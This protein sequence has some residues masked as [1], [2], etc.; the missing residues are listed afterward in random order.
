MGGEKP[1]YTESL[2]GVLRKSGVR[3]RSSPLQVVCYRAGMRLEGK[4][5]VNHL[6]DSQ[7]VW[8]P[9]VL[10]FCLDDLSIGEKGVWMTPVVVLESICCVVNSG[11]YFMK[12]C[13]LEYDMSV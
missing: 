12:L 8:P 9:S 5:S 7:P 10:S 3:W 2:G 13:V 6:L 1:G 11:I 4:E